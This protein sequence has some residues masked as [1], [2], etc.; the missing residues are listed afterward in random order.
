MSTTAITCDVDQR[1]AAWLAARCGM[2]TASRCCDVTATLKKGGES[3]ARRNYRADVIA[4]MLTGQP[5]Q[6]FVSREMQ[7]GI[8][9]E[10]YAIAA[11]EIARDTMV[12]RIGF[13]THPTLM[14]FGASPDG[15]V[16][17]DGLVQ[18]KCPN[19]STHLDW[20]LA[21]TIPLE[22][23]AQMIAELACTGRQWNDFV[24][25]DPRMPAHLQLFVVRLE[26]DETLIALLES[27]VERFND[28]VDSVIAQLPAADRRLVGGTSHVV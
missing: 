7:W 17:S 16:G 2:V 9:Q 8:D 1:S 15:L 23:G 13:I 25:Y 27:E 10:Q 6:H 11:Y 28:D 12:D 20:M 22:H 26:R 18:I 4:E 5:T 14:R 24:S 21:K 19:T 3:A